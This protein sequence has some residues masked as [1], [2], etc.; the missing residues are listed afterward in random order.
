VRIS[1]EVQNR[2]GYNEVTVRTNDAGKAIAI[3]PKAS[4]PG[5]SVNGGE[6][7][8]LALAICFCNDIYREAANRGITVDSVTVTVEGEFGAPGEPATG[9]RYDARIA[10]QASA[11]EIRALA[12][13]T[14][15]LAEVQNTLRAG[16]AVSL[17]SVT[18]QSTEGT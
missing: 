6:L 15:R 18:V 13:E 1:A 5:S 2:A 16:V 8:F 9:I 10:A 3:P 14:D 7:L 17:G 11:E 12:R 4:G